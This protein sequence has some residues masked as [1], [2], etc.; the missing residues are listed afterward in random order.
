MVS[1]VGSDEGSHGMVVKTSLSSLNA[2]TTTIRN[3]KS[4]T[5]APSE[6][7]R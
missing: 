5:A 7:N 6:R 4:V 3:G 1:V 2:V